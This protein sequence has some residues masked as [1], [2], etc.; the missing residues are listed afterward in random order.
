VASARSL[1]SPLA[2][3]FSPTSPL[4]R[5]GRA[6][7]RFNCEKQSEWDDRAETALALLVDHRDE[8][9]ESPEIADFGAGNERLRTLLDSRLTGEL[10]YH[11][12]DLHPQL[13]TTRS[14]NVSQGLP[15]RKFDLAICLGLLE[16][17]PSIPDLARDLRAHCH[18]ALVS[19]V[20]SDSPVA[21]PY[22]NRLQHGWTTHLKGEEIEESF[23][24]A[25]FQLLGS[26]NSDGG[27][28]TLWL[29][30]RDG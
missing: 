15:D 21:I 26:G 14:L 7:R 6:R 29:W 10:N 20:T 5:Q 24:E 27:A 23:R 3:L 13:P 9:P 18:F 2:G 4:T 11:P 19:Y 30:V 12:Y 25:G 17:L 16:Y 8:L 1:L 22:D 28:T